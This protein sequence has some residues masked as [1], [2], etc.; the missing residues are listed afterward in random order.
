MW[1]PDVYEG[2][3][4]PFTA[5]L[6]V[7]P[8]AAGFALLIRFIFQ[9]L[10]GSGP[11]SNNG[12]LT[13]A[14]G[15]AHMSFDTPFLVTLG[16]IAALSMT[17][18]NLA[19]IPQNNVKRMLAY[20]S[21]AH[22]G[23]LMMGV[24]VLSTS[25][26]HAVLLY[27]VFYYLMNFGAFTVCQAVRD[28]TGGEMLHHFR[29]LGTRSPL[30]AMAMTVFLLSLTGLPPLAGFIGKFYLFASVIERGGFWYLI[31]ALIGV[32]NSAI[33][34]YYYL[35]V[36]KAMYFTEAT[37]K[38]TMHIHRGYVFLTSGLA[39]LTV[40]GGLYWAPL[41]HDLKQSLVMVHRQPAN[42]K[43]ATALPQSPTMKAP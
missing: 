15:M 17:V 19:A 21:I 27:L 2:A 7:G 24:V 31:L 14:H 42:E 1:S 28:S 41:S 26:L 11:A 9:G 8:K 25:A 38:T 33:S 4:T 35:K 18:G 12:F 43:V 23:Y 40:I 34:L 16:I 39:V 10:I 32:I 30:L 13:D 3:P 22:A 6:S 29:G 36:V 37:E 5:F 20:S